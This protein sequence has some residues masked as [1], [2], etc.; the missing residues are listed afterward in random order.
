MMFNGGCGTSGQVDPK[1]PVP[2]RELTRAE[3]AAIRKLVKDL[4][5]NYDYEHGCLLLEDNC[6]MF[7]GVAYTN[8]GMC[9]YFRNSVLPAAPALEALLTGRG[10]LETRPCPI[11]SGTFPVIG[12]KAYCSDACA[13]ESKKRKQRGYMRQRRGGS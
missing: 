2:H 10:T 11:C 4:C 3:R 7:Y 6:Y 8:T 13:G 5:A 9:K 12:K 1:S